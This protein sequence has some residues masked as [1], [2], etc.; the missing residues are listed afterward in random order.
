VIALDALLARL[1]IEVVDMTTVAGEFA[2][3]VYARFGKGVGSPGVLNYGDTLSYGV[4]KAADEPL[5]FTG[6]D[7]TETD[8]LPAL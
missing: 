4:A 1:D 6:T 5:L 3:D 8:I 2:R 7:F